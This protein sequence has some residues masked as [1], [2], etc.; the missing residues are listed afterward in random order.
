VQH[1]LLPAL[2]T[3]D[4]PIAWTIGGAPDAVAVSVAFQATSAP[5]PL[6]MFLTGAGPS[7]G[8]ITFGPSDVRGVPRPIRDSA[9]SRGAGCEWFP[10]PEVAEHVVLG[11]PPG[12]VN[13]LTVRGPAKWPLFD[14]VE[15]RGRIV[16]LDHRPTQWPND[17]QPVGQT[18]R[19]F[20]RIGGRHFCTRLPSAASSPT[21]TLAAAHDQAALVNSHLGLAYFLARQLSRRGERTEDLNQVALV[22]LVGASKRFDA[23]RNVTFATFAS[24]SI[25]GELKRHFRDRTWMLRVPRSL[26]E[27]YLDV[28][29]A[30]QELEHALGR[31]PTV[32]EIAANLGKTPE[33]VLAALEAGDSYV[34]ASLDAPYPGDETAAEISLCSTAFDDSI[35]QWEL[36]EHLSTLS[37]L[38]QVV[39]KRLFFEDKL[40]REVADELGVSQMQVS[41]LRVAALAG[42]RSQLVESGAVPSPTTSR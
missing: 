34:P 17:A 10:R 40:Q 16:F 42:L 23:S 31:V 33:Q 24:A 25:L 30:T 15:D 27:S 14:H 12:G 26:K 4:A 11:P 39:I 38:Q 41:R 1:Q 8:N 29:R 32:P 2:H 13:L 7:V 28:R 18:G 21:D 36:T 22:A 3:T 20:E 6:Q 19:V 5:T 35:A 37:V 9:F